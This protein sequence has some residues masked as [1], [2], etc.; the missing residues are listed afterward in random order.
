MELGLQKGWASASISSVAYSEPNTGSLRATASRGAECSFLNGFKVQVTSPDIGI[1]CNGVGETCVEDKTS[2]IGGRCVDLVK[3]K[4]IADNH[5]E[6]VSNCQYKN[7]TIGI[8]CDKMYSCYN[9]DPSKIGCG[10]CIGANACYGVTG[11]VGEGSCVGANA[12][13]TASGN[14][15]NVGD[16]SCVGREVCKGTNGYVTIGDGSC[17]GDQACYTM[18][19]KVLG[20]VTIGDNSCHDFVACKLNE[21]K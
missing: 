12:C 11:Y 17:L 5:R 7:G 3:E 14:H 2:S 19:T 9:A 4:V 10:S 18:D 21:G 1:L 8:K 6:L 16:G 20:S 15:L 13:Y